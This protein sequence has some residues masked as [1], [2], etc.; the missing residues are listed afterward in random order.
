[1]VTS[2][3]RQFIVEYAAEHG[4]RR[5]PFHFRQ[6]LGHHRPRCAKRVL[7]VSQTSFPEKIL[8]GFLTNHYQEVYL[9]QLVVLDGNNGKFLVSDQ[10][11]TLDPE[12]YALETVYEVNHSAPIR[13]RVSRVTA[14][15]SKNGEKAKLTRV[16]IRSILSGPTI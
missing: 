11:G 7:G 16:E 8:A 10:Y 15:T 5:N 14:I 1:M 2:Y 4:S 9:F 13:F 3:T 6:C 12:V